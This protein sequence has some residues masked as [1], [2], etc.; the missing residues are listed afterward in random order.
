[1]K[2]LGVEARPALSAT[3]MLYKKLVTAIYDLLRHLQKLPKQTNNN[4]ITAFV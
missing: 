3:E 2:A 4:K 1:L